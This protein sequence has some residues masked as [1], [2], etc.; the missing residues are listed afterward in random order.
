MQSGNIIKTPIGIIKAR[1][2]CNDFHNS[3]TVD[4]LSLMLRF[5]SLIALFPPLTFHS[6]YE[7]SSVPVFEQLPSPFCSLGRS[8]LSRVREQ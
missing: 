5:F 2:T 1:V 4:H 6:R 7:L 8:Q 3:Y